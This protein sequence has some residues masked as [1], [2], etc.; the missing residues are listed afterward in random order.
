MMKSNICI[1]KYIVEECLNVHLKNILSPIV[2][3][4]I[5]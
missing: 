5:F 3:N 1:K 2:E 4:V